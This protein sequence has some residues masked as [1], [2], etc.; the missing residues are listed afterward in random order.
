VRNISNFLSYCY[1]LVD[2]NVEHSA[3]RSNR[4][5]AK[6]F[7]HEFFIIFEIETETNANLLCL[8]N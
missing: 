8:C 7:Y 1:K 4:M 3:L 5:L 6:L 2:L